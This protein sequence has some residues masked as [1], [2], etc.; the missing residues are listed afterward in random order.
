MASASEQRKNH[1]KGICYVILTA[2]CWTLSSWVTSVIFTSDELGDSFNKPFFLTYVMTSVFI[3]Y[4]PRHC[5]L[6]FPNRDSFF[7]LQTSLPP[8]QLNFHQTLRIAA[9]FCP[10]WFTMNYTFNFSLSET[11]VGSNTVLSTLSGPFCVFWSYLFLQ[12]KPTIGHIIGVFC[13]LGGAAIIGSQDKSSGESSFIG[14]ILAITSACIYG[15]YTTLMKYSVGDDSRLEMTLFFT[16][17]GAINLC[18][19]WPLFFILHFTNIEHFQLPP[20]NI[21]G[22]L[23]I[24]GL[25][26]LS[27]DYFWARSILLSSPLVAT[28]GLTLTIPFALVVDGIQGKRHHVFYVVGCAVI[29][30]GFFL[31]NF[32]CGNRGLYE[33]LEETEPGNLEVEMQERMEETGPIAQKDDKIRGRIQN[34]IPSSDVFIGTPNSSDI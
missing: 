19:F 10:V 18:I 3:L 20:K 14:D 2:I 11:S 30:L 1:V 22:G 16:M 6:F 13:T 12:E 31:V 26:N 32:R 27:S 8:Q 21:A 28:I 4:L 24:N 5:G 9:M 29:L 15:L 7:G 17:L 23:L 25:I 34:K 33:E